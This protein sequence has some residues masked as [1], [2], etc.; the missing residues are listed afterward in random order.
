MAAPTEILLLVITSNIIGYIVPNK[1][2][3]QAINIT[4]LFITKCRCFINK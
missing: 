3:R 4:I 2:V 1:I